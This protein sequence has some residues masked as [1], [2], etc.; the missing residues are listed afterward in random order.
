MKHE[1]EGGRR[2]HEQFDGVRVDGSMGRKGN[3]GVRYGIRPACVYMC[4]R[5]KWITILVRIST[6]IVTQDI[7]PPIVA[8]SLLRQ[9]L[10]Q[11]ITFQVFSDGQM[12]FHQVMLSDE[13]GGAWVE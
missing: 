1:K 10:D 6:Y 9:S 3:H 4:K 5:H 7:E 12:A 13:M 11:V 2:I 8:G